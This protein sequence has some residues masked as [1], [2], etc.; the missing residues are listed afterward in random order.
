[1]LGVDEMPKWLFVED[2]TPP[3]LKPKSGIEIYRTS[4]TGINV[5]HGAKYPFI[6]KVL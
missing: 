4:V 2:I 3:L 5:E 6:A 1:M